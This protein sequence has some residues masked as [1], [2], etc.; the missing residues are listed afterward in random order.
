MSDNLKNLLNSFKTPDELRAYIEA[1][2]QSLIDVSK[3]VKKLEKEK[4][5]LEKKLKKLESTS[6][7]TGN[8]QLDIEGIS[9]SELICLTEIEKLKR[10]TEDRE[11]SYQETQKFDILQKVLNQINS[12]KKNKDS[13]LAKVSDDELLRLIDGGKVDNK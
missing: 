13:S 3:K 8:E 9:N 1:Q 6:K 7:I 12:N 5:E 11:L 2:Q 4:E 10:L